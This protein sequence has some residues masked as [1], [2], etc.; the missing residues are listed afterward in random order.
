MPHGT[1]QWAYKGFA[2]YTYPGDKKKSDRLGS[3][4]YQV[5]TADSIKDDVY[6]Q[7]KFGQQVVRNTDSAATFWA[8]IEP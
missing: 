8:Y 6:R 7:D 1:R 5:L 3:D 4:I 2:T